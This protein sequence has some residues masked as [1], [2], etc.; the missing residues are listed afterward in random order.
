[1]TELRELNSTNL[2]MKGEMSSSKFGILESMLLSRMRWKNLDI[3]FANSKAVYTILQYVVS[4][5]IF[6]I[7]PLI[8][9]DAGIIAEL[10]PSYD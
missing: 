3:I 9:S 1:M 5:I 4:L 10:F 7:S 2:I 6:V 8:L